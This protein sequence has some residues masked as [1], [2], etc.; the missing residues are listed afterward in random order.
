MPVCGAANGETFST[1]RQL[2]TLLELHQEGQLTKKEYEERKKKVEKKAALGPL[3]LRGCPSPILKRKAAA[4]PPPP[5]A[6]ET[7]AE[8][9]E[10]VEEPPAEP[11]PTEEEAAAAREAEAAAEAAADAEVAAVPAPAPQPG[12]E[13]E[14]SNDAAAAEG[15]EEGGEEGAVAEEVME[16]EARVDEYELEAASG[17]VVA[18]GPILDLLPEDCTF[19]D[20]AAELSFDLR[21]LLGGYQGEALFCV[22]RQ[23]PTVPKRDR[24]HCGNNTLCDPRSFRLDK[25]ACF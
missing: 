14:G 16:I 18:H 19:G 25:S 3:D 20:A 2:D 13:P 22:L 17:E 10:E 23:D 11:E 1:R 12:A 5:V 4:T 24:N 9:P 8:T 21:P 7:P 6:E 15:G